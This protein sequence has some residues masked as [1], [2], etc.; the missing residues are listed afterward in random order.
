MTLADL[1]V[2][3]S[4]PLTPLEHGLRHILNW[5]HYSI[6]LPWAWSVVALTVLVRIVLVP[7]MVRQIHSMQNLQRHAPEMKAIQQKYKNDRQKQQEELMKFYR[8]NNVNPAASCL[9]IVLQMPVF[10]ALYFVLKH[11]S[12]HPPSGSLSWLGIVPNISHAVTSHWSGYV[13]LVIYVASQ[14]ASTFYMGAA[15]DK[16]QRTI[17]LVMPIAFVFFIAHFPTGLVLYWMTTNLWVVGQG[18]ITRRLMP[19][20]AAPTLVPKR[21]SRTAPAPA[22]AAV[23]DSKPAKPAAPAQPRRVKRKKQTRRR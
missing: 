12:K 17:L 6:G 22:P 2:A 23:E 9:P 21:T 7:L 11:F 3:S 19:R 18:L 14:M 10:F 8:E 5:L 1:I 16:A 15:M 20:T 13:L 4:N